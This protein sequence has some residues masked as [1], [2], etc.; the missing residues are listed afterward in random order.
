MIEYLPFYRKKF[1]I[2]PTR[3]SMCICNVVNTKSKK[4]KQ[5]RTEC[6]MNAARSYENRKAGRKSF[7][8]SQ[9]AA[10]PVP[11]VPRFIRIPLYT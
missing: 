4:M 6:K 8:V 2:P 10:T 3:A 1:E 9:R 5:R 11:C 7:S